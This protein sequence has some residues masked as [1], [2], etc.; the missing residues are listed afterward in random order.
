MPNTQVNVCN[1]GWHG[2]ANE[3]FDFTN[4]YNND[5]TVLSAGS[6][7]PFVQASPITV[8]AKGAGGPSSVT[9]QLANLANGTYTYS[10]TGC[11]QPE[12][13]MPKDVIIP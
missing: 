1:S 10:V 9:C 3:V 8:P 13:G 4:P 11:P 12:G 6:T 2:N 5:C 7:W